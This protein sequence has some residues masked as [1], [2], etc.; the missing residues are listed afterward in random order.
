MADVVHKTTLVPWYKVNTPDYPTATYLI[1]PAGLPALD[2][3][4]YVPIKYR[5]LITGDTDVGE[6]TA[7]EKTTY[8]AANPPIV[9]GTM[10]AS[11]TTTERDLIIT[12]STGLLWDNTTTNQ[13]ER[14]DG[15][16]WVAVGGDGWKTLQVQDV[17]NQAT[18]DFTTA[19]HF[20]GTYPRL[21][22]IFLGVNGTVDNVQLLLRFK[23]GGAWIAANYTY[24][25]E[26]YRGTDAETISSGSVST[27]VVIGSATYKMGT[28]TNEKFDGGVNLGD[29][30]TTNQLRS[31]KFDAW[32]AGQ[33]GGRG[34]TVDGGGGL[35]DAGALQGIRFWAGSG[36]LN[37]K[38]V[39]LGHK[40]TV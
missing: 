5:K 33:D 39:L 14:Y 36:N 26:T 6:M 8:D 3:A 35:D 23:V 34:C 13:L 10:P 30:S 29:P 20:D 31:C 11:D 38:F 7:G 17:T 9:V 24:R 12:P 27:V 18:V 25:S 40:L 32:G 28:G 4:P 15:T 37:G 2:A 22:V 19:G 21:K 16:A 1:N